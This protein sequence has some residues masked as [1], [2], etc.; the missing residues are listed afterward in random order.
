MALEGVGRRPTP[1]VTPLAENPSQPE[2]TI[3]PYLMPLLGPL[4]QFLHTLNIAAIGGILALY[5]A[6]LLALLTKRR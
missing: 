5:L 3:P 2:E 1:T 4:G 6:L